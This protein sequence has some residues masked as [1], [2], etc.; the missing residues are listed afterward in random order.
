MRSVA[1]KTKELLADLAYENP[2]PEERWFT[3]DSFDPEHGKTEI[4]YAIERGFIEVDVD[5]MRLTEKGRRYLQGDK[6]L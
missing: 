5:R 3:F 2:P 1:Q 4:S 6:E